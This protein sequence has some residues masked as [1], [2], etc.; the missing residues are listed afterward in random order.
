MSSNGIDD[1]RKITATGSIKNQV[2]CSAFPLFF[3]QV[4]FIFNDFV[5]FFNFYDPSVDFL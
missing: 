1:C 4:L 3:R 2:E 5:L